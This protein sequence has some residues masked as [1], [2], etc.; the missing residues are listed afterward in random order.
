MIVFWVS[1]FSSRREERNFLNAHSPARCHRRLVAFR[2]PRKRCPAHPSA[3]SPPTGQPTAR[4][5]RCPPDL[6]WSSTATAAVASSPRIKSSCPRTAT[7][8]G[9]AARCTP[10]PRRTCPTAGPRSQ[11]GRSTRGRCAPGTSRPAA[12]LQRTREPRDRPPPAERLDREVDR[13]ARER[14]QPQRRQVDLVHE[15]R[16]RQQHA[17]A[18]PLPARDRDAPE[19]ADTRRACS[20][21]STTRPSSSSTARR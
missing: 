3:G 5:G 15:R 17:G 6:G 18:H 11:S 7:T 19:R 16:R 1:A 21:R 2:P 10:P 20:S 13:R 14:P 12:R 8:S 4:T 9:T